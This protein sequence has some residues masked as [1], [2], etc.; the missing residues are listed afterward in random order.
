MSW[1]RAGSLQS[2]GIRRKV[3]VEVMEGVSVVTSG[4]RPLPE[5]KHTA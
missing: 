1:L 2:S 5:D 4:P 3:L